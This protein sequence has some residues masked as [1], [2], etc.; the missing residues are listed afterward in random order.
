M[1]H[2]GDYREVIGWD[3]VHER[4]VSWNYGTDGGQPSTQAYD[5]VVIPGTRL[6]LIF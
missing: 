5:T 2:A 3:L 4:I 1:F 6:K